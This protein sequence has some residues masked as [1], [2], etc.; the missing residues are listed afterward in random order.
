[1]TKKMSA[2]ALVKKMSR[3][4]LE[5]I[6]FEHIGEDEALERHIIIEYGTSTTKAH[7]RALVDGMLDGLSG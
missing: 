6:L 5:S 1:M 2:S 4:T 7:Y 3:E